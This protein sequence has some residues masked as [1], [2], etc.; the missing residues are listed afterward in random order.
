MLFFK[1]LILTL[2]LVSCAGYYAKTRSNPLSQYGVYCV[3][4]PMF[5]NKSIIPNA[6]VHMTRSIIHTLSQYD[7]LDVLIGETESCPAILIGVVS[8]AEHVNSAIKAKSPQAFIKG[9]FSTSSIGERNSFYVPD[10]TNVR[11]SVQ[12]ALVKNP[13]YTER[14]LITSDW[15]P[16]IRDNPKIIFNNTFNLSGDFSRFI[17]SNLSP[18]EGG[19]VNYTK[20]KELLDEEIVALSQTLANMFKEMVLY[21]F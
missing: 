21:V 11:L 8:S 17:S 4:I 16:Q 14:Q 6:N 15:G 7:G 13:S 1:I 2:P 12:L 10:T 19:V 20:N 18:D 3:S 9:G 5:I